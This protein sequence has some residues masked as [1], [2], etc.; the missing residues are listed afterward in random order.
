M[1]GFGAFAELAFAAIK[2]AAQVLVHANTGGLPP[3]KVKTVIPKNQRDEIAEIVRKAFDDLEA[4]PQIVKQ[5]QKVVKQEIAKVDLVD[6]ESAIAQIN[7]LLSASRL[8]LQTYEAEMRELED[9]ESLLM[10]I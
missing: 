6:Y 10:L 2:E 3:K 4:P 9:E 7:A 5:E 1:F 8:K